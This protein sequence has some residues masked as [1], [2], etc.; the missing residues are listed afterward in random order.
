MC[1]CAL[2]VLRSLIIFDINS[3]LK[4]NQESLA[5]ETYCGQLGVALLLT[6]GVDF[7]AKKLLK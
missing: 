7:D 3:S 2:L 1:P 5:V 4:Q 6:R